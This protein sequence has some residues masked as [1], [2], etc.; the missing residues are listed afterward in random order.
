MIRALAHRI[1]RHAAAVVAPI[2]P[3][4]AQAVLAETASIERDGEALLWA[5]GCVAASYRQRARPLTLAVFVSRVG[6]ALATALFGLIH[7]QIGQQNLMA[8]LDLMQGTGALGSDRY[9]EIIAS[10]PLEHWLLRFAL[11][12]GL[13]ALH[14]FAA[15]ALLAGRT[16]LVQV[17]ALLV[18]LFA[19]GLQLVGRGGLTLPAIYVAQVVLLSLAAAGM[20]RIERWDNARA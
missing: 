10:Y 16:R 14:I 13:G 3:V 8:K 18:S 4:Q 9:R 15:G 20:A 1:A 19:L 17:T 12:T 7:I 11:L 2:R 5:L 6:T